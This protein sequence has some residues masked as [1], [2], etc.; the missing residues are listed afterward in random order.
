MTP[1]E[2]LA[3][4]L[5]RQLPADAT[6]WLE[7]SAGQIRSSGKDADVYLAVSLVTRKVGKADLA[8][9]ESRPA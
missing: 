2:L 5:S 7:K 9:S 6:A 3:R 1:R 8:L 4:W